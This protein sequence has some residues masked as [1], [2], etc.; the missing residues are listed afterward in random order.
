M[1]V[2][3]DPLSYKVDIPQRVIESFKR[4]SNSCDLQ[5]V[6]NNLAENVLG[7]GGGV[8]LHQQHLHG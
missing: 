4:L 7:G 8:R 5:L 1:L 2:K 3:Q 6:M